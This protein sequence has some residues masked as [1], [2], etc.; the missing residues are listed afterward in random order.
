M[1]TTT[2]ST[3]DL[4]SD[5]GNGD[6][7]TDSSTTPKKAKINS[8]SPVSN[9]LSDKNTPITKT[10][11]NVLDHCNNFQLELTMAKQA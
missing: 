1:E 11:K 8:V 9:K 2:T 3:S 6:T 5:S 7:P 10:V 4:E